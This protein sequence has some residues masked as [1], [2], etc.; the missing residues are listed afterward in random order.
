MRKI[1]LSSICVLSLGASLSACSSDT[2]KKPLEGERLSI[3]DLR[4]DLSPNSDQSLADTISVPP[5][6]QNKD[7]PQ[8]GGYPH[9]ALEN[10]SFGDAAQL[11]RIWQADIGTGSSKQLPL[12]A[13]PIAANGKVFTL[14]TRAN[15]RA[16]HNQTGKSLWSSNV[17]H[18][19]EKE[20]VIS[21]GL[22]YDNNIVYVTSGY[23]EVLALNAATGAIIWRTKISAG[24]RAAPTIKNGRVFVK[25]MNNNAIALDSQTGKI[26][27]EY[28]GVG[29]TTALL[30][31]ASPV[32]DDQLVIP[33]FSSGDLVALRVENG[34]VVWSDS[35]ANSLRLGGMAGLSDIRGLPVMK[36][37]LVLAVSFGGKMAAFDKRNGQRLWQKEISSA[38]TPW[39]SGNTVYVLSSDFN[40]MALNVMNGDI[41]WVSPVQK[42]ENAESHKGLLSWAGPIMAGGRL[43][44]SAS[45][46][47]ML[48]IDPKTGNEITRWDIKKPVRFAPIV[49][50]GTLFIIAEDGSLLAYR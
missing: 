41:L 31:A 11:T 49:A 45:N 19:T 29:E 7:W 25:G 46:G 44:L 18:L 22:A 30:G 4:R 12:T 37:D 3:L 5:T 24:S 34:A 36:G 6:V 38:E 47:R 8:S 9:H 14:D 15:V 28:E 27:W 17:Q 13:Q 2:E 40:L 35:L 10:L 42:Y 48:E 16:F 1:L 26:L 43:I 32:A 20:P 50:D 23:D 39:L 21:G 33:A